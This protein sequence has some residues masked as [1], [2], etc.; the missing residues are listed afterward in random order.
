M[1]VEREPV[2]LRDDRELARLL[3][4]ACVGD[5][6]RRMG[7]EQPDQ[8]LVLVAEVRGADLL[9]QVE[10]ADHAR[11]RDDRHA[12]ERAHVRVALGPPAAE[13]RVLVDVAGAVGGLRCEHGTEDAVLPGQRAE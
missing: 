5:R 6:D 13:A 10:G 12:E 8:L 11:R 1:Q 7:G 2:P 3:V 9:R 4:Q